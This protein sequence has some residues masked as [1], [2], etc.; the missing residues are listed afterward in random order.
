MKKEHPN[1]VRMELVDPIS[2]E[3]VARVF[4]A[5]AIKYSPWGWL[6]GQQYSVLIGA[7]ERHLLAFKTGRVIDEESG[8]HNMA[9]VIAN[10]IML[11][12]LELR[13]MRHRCDDYTRF[14]QIGEP[15]DESGPD[16]HG[17]N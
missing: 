7:L 14:V 1:K 11:L 8:E 12:G 5:G 3:A 16:Y 4:T 15:T 6:D 17:S 9:H 13:G 2:I 10:A